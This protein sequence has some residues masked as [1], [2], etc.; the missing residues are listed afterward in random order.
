MKS[1]RR[2]VGGHCDLELV[3]CIQSET[4]LCVISENI[5]HLTAMII[6]MITDLLTSSI[7]KPKNGECSPEVEKKVRT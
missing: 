7:K 2:K 1:V 5:L 4:N 6:D 3:I